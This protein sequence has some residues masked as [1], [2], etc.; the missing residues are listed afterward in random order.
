MNAAAEEKAQNATPGVRII[1][2]D[3]GVQLVDHENEGEA[4]DVVILEEDEEEEVNE[5]E[6][7]WIEF[8]DLELHEQRL[9]GQTLADLRRQQE[10]LDLRL[11]NQGSDAN[12]IEGQPEN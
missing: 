1:P 5:D 2:V 3:L 9:C 7:S 11:G 4:A 6:T 12:E 10:Q 8:D